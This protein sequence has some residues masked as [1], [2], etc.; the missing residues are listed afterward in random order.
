MKITEIPL[1]AMRLQ[2]RIARAPLHLIEDRVITRMDDEAPGRLFFERSVGSM[3]AMVAALLHDEDVASRGASQVRRSQA[4]GE[5]VRL[6][7]VAA[8][9]RAEADEKMRRKHD[10][11]IA[12]PGE[13]REQA[14]E[15]MREARSAAASR[16][17]EDAERVAKRTAETKARI[18]QSAA[19]KVD[20]A[21]AAKRTREQRITAAEKSAEAVADAQLE[22]AA[23][24][25]REAVNKQAHADR[26]EDVAETEKEQR[27]AARG[28]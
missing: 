9:Q 6:D 28:S 2:Y 27:K 8:E 3:D 26:L 5:A 25:R 18:D 1:A 17:A 7:E 14:Q 24:K 19:A 16:K 4:L 23:D 21:E 12:A 10:E 15:K 13:A 11:V 22:D 20:A